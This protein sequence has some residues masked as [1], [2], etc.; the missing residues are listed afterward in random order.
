[1]RVSI[2][3]KPNSSIEDPAATVVHVVICRQGFCEDSIKG[4]FSNTQSA[5]KFRGEEEARLNA[6]RWQDFEVFV[7]PWEVQG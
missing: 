5:E 6:M 2:D 3:S 4:I 1:M 7:R